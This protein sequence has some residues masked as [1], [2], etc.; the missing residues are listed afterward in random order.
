MYIVHVCVS[1]CHMLTDT[2]GNQ[3]GALD[4]LKLESQEV[5]SLLMWVLGVKVRPSC[6]IFHFVYIRVFVWGCAVPWR[7]D[8]LDLEL[9]VQAGVPCPGNQTQVFC[10]SSTCS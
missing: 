5:V 4:P 9:E 10:Q 1:E 3:Q 6:F 2:Q 7:P 8:W